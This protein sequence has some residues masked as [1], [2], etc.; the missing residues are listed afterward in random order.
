MDQDTTGFNKLNVGGADLVAAD[1]T[2]LAAITKTAAQIN[3]LVAGVAAGYKLARGSVLTVA[4]SDDINT[5]LASVIACV[6]VL[7][8]APSVDVLWV[9]AQ[10]GNQA[11]APAAGHILLKS[12][13]PTAVNDVTPLPATVFGKRVSFIA[14]GT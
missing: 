13:K 9:V 5:G 4:A 6:A 11:G 14:I 10:V 12:F 1:I 8:D 2:K 7:E 3:L